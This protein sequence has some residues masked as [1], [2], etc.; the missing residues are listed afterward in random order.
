MPI[1]TPVS[2][3]LPA[4]ALALAAAASALAGD[5]APAADPPDAA[6]V[7]EMLRSKEPDQRLAGAKAA[8]D[9]QAESVVAPLCSLLRD[10]DAGIR[11]ATIAALAARQSVEGKKKAATALAAELPRLSKK[12]ETSGDL[13]LVANALGELAQPAT[14]DALMAD[15]EIDTPTDVIKARLMA[16]ANAPCPDAIE[17]LIQFL[18]KQGRGRNGMQHQACRQ[19]LKWATGQDYGGDPDAWR[20]WWKDAEKTFD[21]DEAARRRD[22]EKAKDADKERR[23]KEAREKKE[24]REK[25]GGKGDGGKKEGGAGD[26]EKKD[27]P[28]DS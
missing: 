7:A 14:V 2:R 18:A 16:I 15:I 25:Q 24:Q 22:A 12:L 1:P 10:D 9:E 6:K 11:R 3:I 20:M 4:F 19:A 27:A 13:I 5:A 26:G 8:K 17:S 23:Q 28:K 21:F